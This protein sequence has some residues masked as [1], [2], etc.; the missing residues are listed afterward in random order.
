[1]TAIFRLIASWEGCGLETSP[2]KNECGF[3]GN[4]CDSGTMDLTKPYIRAVF[5]AR[6]QPLPNTTKHHIPPHRREIC[7]MRRNVG[8]QDSN[9]AARESQQMTTYRNVLRIRE[10]SDRLA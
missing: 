4:T 10:R 5:G 3:M 9:I 8:P 7:A 1:M 2:C 6:A